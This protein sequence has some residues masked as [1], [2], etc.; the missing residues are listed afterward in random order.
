MFDLQT[1]P[2]YS[3][4]N[5]PLAQALGQVRYPLIADFD[6]MAGI[7]PL[8][9]ELREQFPY[10]QQEK[11]QEFAFVAGPAGPASGA[12]TETKTWNFTNDAGT[13]IVVGPGSTTLSIGAGYTDFSSFADDFERILRALNVVGV[14]RCDRLGLRYLSAVGSTPG[15]AR[16]WAKW[17]RTEL[18]SWSGTNVI[19][20]TCSVSSISQVQIAHPPAGDYSHFPSAIH[21]VVRHGAVPAGTLVPG[22]PPIEMSERTYILDL[23]VFS[24]GNQPFNPTAIIEQFKALHIEIDRFF[25]WSMSDDGRSNFGLEVRDD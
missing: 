6:T 2:R 3:L 15:D 9:R 22:I 11:V 8:Q 18:L 14:P 19:S 20:E 10:M 24:E 17:F 13:L 1:P 7:A 25:Y 23:D 21:A 4:A 16:P 12:A 5:A